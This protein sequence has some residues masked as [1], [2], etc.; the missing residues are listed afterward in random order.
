VVLTVAVA[1]AFP[2]VLAG[3]GAKETGARGRVG[4]AAATAPA[5]AAGA[6][7]HVQPARG[8]LAT[9]LGTWRFEIRFAGNYD[10]APDATGTRVIRTLFDDLRVEWTEAFDHSPLEGQGI[11]GFDPA[12]DRFFW[13]AVYSTGSAPELLTGALDDAQPTIAF[14]PVGGGDLAAAA[15]LVVVDNDH[16]TW[17]APDRAWRAVFTRQR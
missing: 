16:L 11:V 12:S 6:A 8:I 5:P 1:G 7:A 9:L 13:N 10:G 14:R 4:L 17:V 15:T 3:Q 2:P